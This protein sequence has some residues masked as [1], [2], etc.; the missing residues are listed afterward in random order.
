M[1]GAYGTY[2]REVYSKLWSENLVEKDH[3]EDKGFVGLDNIKM[4]LRGCD[5]NLFGSEQLPVGS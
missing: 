2:V 5:L 1:D 3:L 4:D